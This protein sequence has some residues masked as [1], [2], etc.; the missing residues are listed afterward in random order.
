MD[1][2]EILGVLEELMSEHL[3]EKQIFERAIQW[4]GTDDVDYPYEALVDGGRWRLR[5]NDFPDEPLYT[6]F[7]EDR[8]WGH[9]DDLP[10]S[11]STP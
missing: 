10:P 9:F 1:Q 6:L 5:L 4:T 3:T 7:I 2:Y 11:W 8:E